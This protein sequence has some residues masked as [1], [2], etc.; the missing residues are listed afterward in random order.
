MSDQDW[1]EETD[2]VEFSVRCVMFGFIVIVKICVPPEE[3]VCTKCPNNCT[4]S[5]VLIMVN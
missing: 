3:F 1:Q 4:V 2:E 5:T